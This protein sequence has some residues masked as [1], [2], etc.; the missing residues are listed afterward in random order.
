MTSNKKPFNNKVVYRISL[1]TEMTQRNK[2]DDLNGWL[3]SL[4]TEM[5]QPN[6]LEDLNG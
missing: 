6:K 1:G 2:F 3:A 5:T 4:R